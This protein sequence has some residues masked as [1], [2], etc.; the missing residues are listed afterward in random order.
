MTD[1]N[2]KKS[3]SYYLYLTALVVSFVSFLMSRLRYLDI[4]LDRDEGTYLYMG[5]MF[6]RGFKPYVDFYEIKP[7][8]I[9]FAYGIFDLIFGY[10]NILLHV[11]LVLM[12]I[13]IGV[14]IYKLGQA[15]C[16]NSQ[17]SFIAA[18]I[19]F[20]LVL[21]TNFVGFAILSEYFFI[22]MILLSLFFITKLKPGKNTRQLLWAG[23]FFGF[24]A[25]V[26]QHA[27]YFIVP[28]LFL[29]ITTL[30]TNK[31]DVLKG[32]GMFTIGGLCLILPLIGYISIIGSFDE[33]IDWIW[34]KPSGTYLSTISWASGKLYLISFLQSVFR[35]Y[36]PLFIFPGLGIIL[37]AGSYF[38]KGSNKAAA[39]FLLLFFIFSFFSTF[40]G[41]RFYGH[42]WLMVI[43]SVAMLSGN[44]IPLIVKNVKVNIVLAISL[45]FLIFYQINTTKNV[46]YIA[47][48]S[49]VY[50]FVYGA[51]P[52]FALDRMITYLNRKLQVNDKIYVFG[53]EPQVY[54]ECDKILNIPHVYV[55]F[56]HIPS[57]EYLQYQKD[58]KQFLEKNKPEYLIHI[59]NSISINMKDESDHFLYNWIFTF[60]MIN[61]H[62]VGV[63]EMDKNNVPS[64]FFDNDALR[65][66]TLTDN[67]I[68]I[69]K[70]NE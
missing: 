24:A 7:P 13:G 8:G 3:A 16:N 51:N 48:V 66:K 12:Q 17:N 68:I 57:K 15:L 34:I 58:T 29:L 10:N 27:I 38:I 64:Y 70:R 47:K 18:A 35:T 67:Y 21:I 45:L 23:F 2:E 32:I 46:N 62:Q 37:A 49:D 28:V 33:M 5:K 54:Y 63:A 36:W 6:M 9:F 56:L 40:P 59:Q 30:K 44:L 14:L 61:Y 50:R 22:A 60:E 20:Q 42:Y 65:Y 31:N 53:S 41:Y 52:N 25:M 43:P 1:L 69:Y 39:T 26:R 55:G 19:Y 4:P 11:G